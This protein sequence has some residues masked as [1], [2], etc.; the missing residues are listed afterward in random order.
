ME[1][2]ESL[3]TVFSSFRSLSPPKPDTTDHVVLVQASLGR[4]RNRSDELFSNVYEQ[5]FA[6]RPELRALFPAEMAQ[7][8]AKLASALQLVIENLRCP[9]HI[10]TL[11]EE[12]GNR[13]VAYG[14]TSEHLSVLGDALLTSLEVFDPMPWDDDTR[15]AWRAAYAAVASAMQRGLR[16]GTLTRPDI[17]LPPVASA[18]NG[19]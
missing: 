8:R 6:R 9:E 15:E 12:L 4:L 14:A 10:V 13:H 19:S 11:L 16:S 3:D 1:A 17:A 5:L 2:L 18:G 7:Q